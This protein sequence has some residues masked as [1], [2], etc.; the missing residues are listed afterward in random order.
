MYIHLHRSEQR[1]PVSGCSCD[2]PSWC[3]RLITNMGYIWSTG[4]TYGDTATFTSTFWV[5]VTVEVIY[6]SKICLAQ[7]MKDGGAWGIGRVKNLKSEET[8]MQ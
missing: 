7:G 5:G 3:S 8:A 1:I 6:V 2:R 4:F